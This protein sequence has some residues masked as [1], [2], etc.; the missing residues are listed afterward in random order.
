MKYLIVQLWRK[1]WPGF[2]QRS[3]TVGHMFPLFLGVAALLSATAITGVDKSHLRL[4]PSQSLVMKGDSFYIDVY[5]YAH[6]PVNA[7]DVEIAFSEDKVSVE[8]VDKGKSVLT[9]WAKE[10][11]ITKGK[12][13]FS[14]GTYQRGFVGE[15]VVATI[16]ATA[17]FTGETKF[18]VNNVTLLA[19][20]GTGSA[21]TLENKTGFAKSFYIYDEDEDVSEIKAKIAVS[22][23]ADIDG[24][25]KVSLKDISSFMASWHNKDK[26]YD[27]NSDGKMNFIDFSIILAKSFLGL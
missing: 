26:T 24:D 7:V 1:I 9:I 8:S 19:G 12:I 13:A 4:E 11:T 10:P 17:K 14:G 27:F 23:T 6:V 3:T 22:I 5:A 25:G 15:H 21:V 2:G 18:S 20:D 16:K